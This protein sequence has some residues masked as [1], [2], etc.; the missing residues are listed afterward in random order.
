LY[1]DD[2]EKQLTS[3]IHEMTHYG[4]ADDDEPNFSEN[5]YKLEFMVQK[6]SLLAPPLRVSV[7]LP[8]A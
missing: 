8:E 1:F 5:T 4:G 3:M 2:P 7:P 6:M